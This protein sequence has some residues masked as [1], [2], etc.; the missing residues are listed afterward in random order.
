MKKEVGKVVHKIVEK[1]SIMG[2]DKFVW[3][4]KG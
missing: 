2:E 3:F 4:F 1:M